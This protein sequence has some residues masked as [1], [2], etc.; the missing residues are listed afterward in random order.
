MAAGDYLLELVIR[1]RNDTAAAFNQ[2]QAS[3]DRI[4]TAAQQSARGVTGFLGT[5]D[6]LGG[7]MFAIQQLVAPLQQVGGAIVDA[8]A[9]A[10]TFRVA[11]VRIQG[12]TQ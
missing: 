10:E 6:R 7:T 11:M 5:F 3:L 8:G 1:A 9:N 4:D 2:I 12:D